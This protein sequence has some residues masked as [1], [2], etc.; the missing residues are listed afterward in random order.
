MLFS[1]KGI[2]YSQL[3]RMNTTRNWHEVLKVN[4][5]STPAQIKESYE[6]IINEYTKTK[7]P[8]PPDIHEAYKNLSGKN[9]KSILSEYSG[10]KLSSVL[11]TLTVKENSETRD[12]YY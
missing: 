12:E 9:P 8:I 5:E 7:S 11:D 10:N 2:K 6:H 1:L 3:L 4:K